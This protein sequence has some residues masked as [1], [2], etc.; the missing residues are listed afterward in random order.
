MRTPTKTAALAAAL[1]L[2]LSLTPV[3]P[4]AAA[5]PAPN[6]GE[7]QLNAVS[8]SDAAD[9]FA[10]GGISRNG[11]AYSVVEHTTDAGDHWTRQTIAQGP[12]LT[13]VSAVSAS[14]AYA[15]GHTLDTVYKTTNG[16]VNWT[17]LKVTGDLSQARNQFE[18]IKF[19]DELHGFAVGKWTQ[20]SAPV[21]WSTSDGG[22]SWTRS[23]V[24]PAFF[25]A[26]HNP[27]GD[28][29]FFGVGA[30]DAQ[31]AIAVG[32]EAMSGGAIGYRTGDG[33]TWTTESL[34]AG[35]TQLTAV[36]YLDAT[37]ALAVG[38]L[39]KTAAFDGSSWTAVAGGAGDPNGVALSD[40]THGWAVGDGGVIKK[41]NGTGWSAQ[42]SPVSTIDLKD[43]ASVSGTTAFAV[44]EGDTFLRTTDGTTWVRIGAPSVLAVNSAGFSNPIAYALKSLLSTKMT[45]NANASSVHAKLVVNVPGGAWTIYDGN[46]ANKV[47]ESFSLPAWNGKNPAT[48]QKAPFAASYSWTLTLSKAGQ[49]SVTKS[50]TIL[51]STVY[52][53]MKAAAGGATTHTGSGYLQSPPS[54]TGSVNIYVS[55]AAPSADK[56]AI[57]VTGPAGS[58]YTNVVPTNS[59]WTLPGSGLKTGQL[60]GT[61]KIPTNG[62]YTFTMKTNTTGVAYTISVIE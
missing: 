4:A 31:H 14:V 11:V 37:D 9:G 38:P 60:T 44:G 33:S 26:D 48:G 42:T 52:F 7:T 29:T 54:A 28:G 43:V 8:F 1:A 45:F 47:G 17:P 22:A 23:F 30:F 41:W 2:L 10:V 25:D 35:I 32:R 21:V 5:L 40:A 6:P 49:P 51:L 34:P 39:G 56:L 18:S 3:V 62:V 20:T 13:C 59:P 46:T 55:A 57:G 61:K 36:S 19:T 27:I 53:Q 24:G 15:A 50:G 16:G 12:Y 58:R